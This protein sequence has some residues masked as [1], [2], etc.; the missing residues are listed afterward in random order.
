VKQLPLVSIVTPNYNYACFLG[1]TIES[2][3]KQD[4]P[5]VE[6]IIVDDGS[7]DDSCEVARHYQRRYPGRIQLI[8]Q[9]NRGQSAAINHG[10]R[11]A[12]GDIL[13]WL[14][15]DDLLQPSAISVAVD[16]LIRHPYVG[17]VFADRMVIDCKGNFLYHHHNCY[18]GDWHFRNNCIL[19]QETAFWRRSL[20]FDCGALDE[21]LHYCMDYDLFCRFSLATRIG[22]IPVVTGSYREHSQSKTVRVAE[23]SFPEGQK[24]LQDTL[25]KYFGVNI[26]SLER[27]IIFS[28]VGNLIRLYKRL[29]GRREKVRAREI[30]AASSFW[31]QDYTLDGS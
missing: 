18:W 6:Y 3:M 13:G 16:Y 4:Y 7:T 20:F 11:V 15:S 25:W 27:R 1:E 8:S 22:F 29:R 19:A 2:V 9:S 14:N 10:F 31:E 21:S 26:N 12:S 17:M 23:G 5:R 28:P 24:E 30:Q